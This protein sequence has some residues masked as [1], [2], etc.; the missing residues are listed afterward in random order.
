MSYFTWHTSDNDMFNQ[1]LIDLIGFPPRFKDE[2]I[3]QHHKDLA[4]SLQGWYEGALYFIIN[5]ITNSWEC[6]N[7]VL[8]GGCAYNGTANGKIKTATSIK[9]VFIPFAPSDSGSAIGACLYQHHIVMGNSKV[10]GGDNQSPYLGEDK[11][12]NL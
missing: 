5:R 3:E 1:K 9:N 7:L 12:Q 2:P 8:G 6:E 11:N 10:K 4:A